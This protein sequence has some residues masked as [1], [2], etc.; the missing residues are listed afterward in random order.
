MALLDSETAV[1]AYTPRT[2]QSGDLDPKA[3]VCIR[4]YLVESWTLV[5]DARIL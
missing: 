4:S 5:S 3:R 2:F 1:G